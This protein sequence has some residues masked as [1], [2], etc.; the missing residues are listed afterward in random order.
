VATWNTDIRQKG[1]IKR[2]INEIGYVSMNKI[3]LAEDCAKNSLLYHGH[4]PIWGPSF[5][6]L[7]F[8]CHIR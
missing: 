1:N 3:K 7:F 6:M 4:W 2:E 8:V 5:L